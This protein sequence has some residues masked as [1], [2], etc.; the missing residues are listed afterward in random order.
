M[1]IS[2]K[3]E[4]ALKAIFDLSSQYLAL[5]RG[6]AMPPIKIGDI[7][8]R[9][10]IPQKFLELI[11]AG[12]KQSGFVDSRRGAEGG[13]LLARSPDT[14]TVG[15]VL[16]AVENFRTSGRYNNDNPFGE[17]WNRVDGAMSDVLDKTSF[18]EIARNWQ[19]KHTEYVPNWEI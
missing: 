18:G 17:I 9:Q 2:V 19:K 4:Y 15:D 1:N 12:L 13:Y 14:I 16:R 7:A 10:K 8:K 5:S 3:S 6:T 11:L